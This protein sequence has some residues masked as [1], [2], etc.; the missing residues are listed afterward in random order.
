MDVTATVAIVMGVAYMIVK[1][2]VDSI[3]KV[4]T[5]RLELEREYLE[6]MI[7]DLREIK[8]RLEH[9]ETRAPAR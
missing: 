9:L 4:R 7:L 3:V 1:L 5:A 8:E 6:Q 2:I